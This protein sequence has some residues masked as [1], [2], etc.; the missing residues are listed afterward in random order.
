MSTVCETQEEVEAR[1][2][3]RPADVVVIGHKYRPQQQQAASQRVVGSKYP[4]GGYGGG[5][6][7]YGGCSRCDQGASVVE[8]RK[9]IQPPR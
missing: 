9:S 6:G 2:A 3:P 8:S 1:S 7:G 5:Q 4:Q